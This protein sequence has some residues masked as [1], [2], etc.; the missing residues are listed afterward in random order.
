MTTTSTDGHTRV[1]RYPV[2]HTDTDPRFTLGLILDVAEV[3]DQHGYPPLTGSNAADLV[4]LRQA[5]F[6][7]LYT[8]GGERA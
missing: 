5:L 2:A 6:A 8:G 1:R 4:E 3:L 7:F